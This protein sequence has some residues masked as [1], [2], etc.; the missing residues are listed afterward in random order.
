MGVVVCPITSGDTAFRS[1]RLIFADALNYD[2]KPIKNRLI[3]CIPIFVAA[4]IL[5]NISFSTLWNYVGI[6]NQVLATITLWTCAAYFVSVKKAHWLMS[7]PATFLTFICIC[8]FLTAPVKD[9]GMDLAPEL[10]YIA[11]GVIAAA[12]LAVFIRFAGKR[13]QL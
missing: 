9:G 5:C 8:F 12:L 10:G 4:Y 7:L 1:L 11:G 6:G 3:M 13:D 2:Q